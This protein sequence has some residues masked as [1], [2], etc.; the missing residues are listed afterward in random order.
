MTAGCWG[1]PYGC[2]GCWGCWGC[3]GGPEMHGMTI[4]DPIRT[5]T[6]SKP[7][8]DT[9]KDKETRAANRARLIVELPADAK[10]FVDDQAMK[11]PSG[12]RSFTTPTLEKGE[13][14][15]YVLKVEVMRDGKPVTET[16]KVLVK[17][18][19]EI[20]ADFKD[21]ETVATAKAR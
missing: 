21:M 9:E 7:M 16:K 2:Y 17:A 11:T 6:P 10:L 20:K 12:R 13:T 3:A 8:K 4:G 5:E 19:D 1:A 18:G 15:Y 14:Y